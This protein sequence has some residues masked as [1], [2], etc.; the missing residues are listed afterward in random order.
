MSKAARVEKRCP[1]CQNEMSEVRILDKT[2]VG[3]SDGYLLDTCPGNSLRVIVERA[4]LSFNAKLAPD[5]WVHVAA[6]V[7]AD[8]TRAL[9]VS[10]KRVA[11]DTKAV[12]LDAA[13]LIA[14]VGKLRQ[15]HD[16]LVA[17]GL[18]ASYEAA[19]ARLAVRYLDTSHRRL[20]LLADGGLPPLPPASQFAA[21]KCYLDT[22][23][24]LCDGLERAVRS[25][26]D[27][28]DP[29]EKRAYGLWGQ[30]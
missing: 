23:A 19:H 4:P 20:A 27:S 11:V 22:T 6:T 2:T 18:G 28:K 3:A 25:Y 10:G 1:D 29:H 12:A 26:K 30:E 13:A 7:A 8:G 15:F 14:R 21:D 5:Q 17:A 24:K 16:R 9:Y